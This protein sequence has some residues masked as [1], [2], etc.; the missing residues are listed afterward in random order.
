SGETIARL[1]MS[2]VVAV[3]LGAIQVKGRAE[4]VRCFQIDRLG[5]LAN[6]NP[7]PAPEIPIGRA[8][9]AGFH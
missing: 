8:A 7:A 5:L 3:D 6:P 2:D 4:P 9:V 1:G